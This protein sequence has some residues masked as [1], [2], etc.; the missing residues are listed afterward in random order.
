[1]IYMTH[2]AEWFDC[3]MVPVYAYARATDQPTDDAV[4]LLTQL[5]FTHVLELAAAL[6]F[7]LIEDALGREPW[8]AS[9]QR[10]VREYIVQCLNS[11]QELPAEF[12]YLPLILGGITV[13][14]EVT[15]AGED[16]AESLRLLSKAK[17]ER[18]ELFAEPDLKDLNDAFDRLV[19]RQA[20][21]RARG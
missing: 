11:G 16:V 4:W 19:A 9:E 13:A 17:S 3:L 18:Q 21:G 20:R 7:G 10:L 15:F 8:T 6:S 12:L 5:G 14:G 2:N 1:V